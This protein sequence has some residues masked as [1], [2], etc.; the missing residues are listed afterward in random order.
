VYDYLYV[1][2]KAQLVVN[3]NDPSLA[4]GE[5]ID[6][7]DRAI[8]QKILPKIHGNRSTLGESLKAHAAFL[9]GKNSESDPAAKY[10][11]GLD[12]VIGI[13]LSKAISLPQGKK[14]VRSQ[15]KLLEMQTLLVARNY[16]S[17]VK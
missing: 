11:L 9:D 2:T 8:F 16:V 10:T 13:E 6:G 1:W 14:F 17:F 3:N 5:W 7:L 4:M 12:N 15:A